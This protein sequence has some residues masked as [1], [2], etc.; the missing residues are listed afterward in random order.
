MRQVTSL[1]S[2]LS[3]TLAGDHFPFGP[4]G[5]TVSGR[6]WKRNTVTRTEPSFAFFRATTLGVPLNSSIVTSEL[7]NICLAFATWLASA[8]SHC[9]LVSDDDTGEV[10]AWSF[11]GTVASL[12]NT[13]AHSADAEV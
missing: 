13:H 1:G 6:H 3:L 12:H 4:R 10:L 9:C 2:T 7:A 11:G 5:S 8:C